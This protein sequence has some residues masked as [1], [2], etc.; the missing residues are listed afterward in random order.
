MVQITW[1]HNQQELS[2]VQ[3]DKR[4]VLEKFRLEEVGADQFGNYS[5]TA[6]NNLTSVTDTV[7]LSG[8]ISNN[9]V[10]YEH[11]LT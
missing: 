7:L 11:C 10:I 2:V 8:I 3:M 9:N 4:S 6:T 1:Y 5:C